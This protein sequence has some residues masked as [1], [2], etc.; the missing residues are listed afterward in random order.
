[1]ADLTSRS[2]VL[3]S[4]RLTLKL[5]SVLTLEQALA[6]LTTATTRV[7]QCCADK[8]GHLSREHFVHVLAGLFRAAGP[9][10]AA[11]VALDLSPKPASTSH[12]TVAASAGDTPST[13]ARANGTP[14]TPRSRRPAHSDTDKLLTPDT[15]AS[16]SAWAISNEDLLTGAAREQEQLPNLDVGSHPPK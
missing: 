15:A 5:P 8:T 10:G 1:M 4:T 16:E 2:R 14:A 7:F 11:A 12:S 3:M 9:D 13:P 6:C